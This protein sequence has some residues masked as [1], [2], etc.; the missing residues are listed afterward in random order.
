[1]ALAC[2]VGLFAANLLGK[3][4]YLDVSLQET[5]LVFAAAQGVVHLAA[6]TEH[7]A[8]EE[9]LQ[10]TLA[11]FR[12]LGY[13]TLF[14]AGAFDLYLEN[15]VNSMTP[16]AFQATVGDPTYD[17]SAIEFPI[18]CIAAVLL[19]ALSVTALKGQQRSNKQGS[20]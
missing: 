9:A 18:L 3:N 1:V 17:Y 20:S 16:F 12:Q 5:T 7:S 15:R 6:T 14:K 4:L 19:I 8:A 10:A 13:R 11:D 2:S